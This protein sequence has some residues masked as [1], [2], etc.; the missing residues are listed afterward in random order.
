VS[1]EYDKLVDD[2]AIETDEATRHDMYIQAEKMLVE[3]EAAIIPIYWYT[4]VDLTKPAVTRTFGTGGQE[5]YEKW[6]I[7]R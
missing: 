2:A 3:D 1:E 6:T 4:Q 5:A 7:S